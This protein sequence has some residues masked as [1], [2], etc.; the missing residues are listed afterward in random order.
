VRI[1]IA[2]AGIAITACSQHTLFDEDSLPDGN[3][4]PSENAQAPQ[5]RQF[6]SKAQEARAHHYWNEYKDQDSASNW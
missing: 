3:Q 2:L 4:P 1:L 6:A 5:E